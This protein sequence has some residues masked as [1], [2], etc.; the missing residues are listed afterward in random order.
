MKKALVVFGFVIAV[1][2][3]LRADD[4]QAL[5]DAPRVREVLRLTVEGSTVSY[6][7]DEKRSG[8]LHEQG[9][10][11]AAPGS[12]VLTYHK[13]NPF[14]MSVVA[15]ATA[16]DDSAQKAIADFAKALAE[17]SKVIIPAPGGA[18][19]RKIAANCAALNTAVSTLKADIA[20]TEGLA[21]TA[22]ELNAWIDEAEGLAGVQLAVKDIAQARKKLSEGDDTGGG[23]VKVENDMRDYTAA[24]T[25][26]TGCILD[27]AQESIVAAFA[28]KIAALE[29]MQ[30][31]LDDITKMLL[32]YRNKEWR[33]ER[34]QTD[35]VF[36]TTPNEPG[37]GQTVKVKFQPMKYA[38][39]PATNGITASK[40]TEFSR[41]FAVRLLWTAVPQYGVAGIWNSLRYPKYSVKDTAGTKTV[42]RD[43]DKSNVDMAATLNLFCRCWGGSGLYPGIQFGV[44]KAKDYPGIMLGGALLF[45]G[46]T[47]IAVAAGVMATWYKDLAAL[48]VG[49]PVESEDALKK[50]LKLRMSKGAFYLGV[51][52]NF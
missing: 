44:S 18:A 43:Y 41:S 22:R 38:I 6:H 1:A 26:G 28:A 24:K 42:S 47:H 40:D 49:G 23:V 8:T 16:F 9:D 45:T 19:A 48:S 5:L 14:K 29:K 13:F 30:T 10:T 39:D 3:A 37:K 46:Q 32:T 51:Q 4:T 15:E 2:S 36:F 31:S 20:I 21:P 12:V 50:D 25:K 17:F 33:P 7:T 34:S 11:F 35:I 27:A 52:Y